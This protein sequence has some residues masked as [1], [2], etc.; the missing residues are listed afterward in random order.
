MRVILTQD[1]PN[2]GRKGEVKTVADGYAR[3]LLLP[4][5]LAVVASPEAIL[6]LEAQKFRQ[7]KEAEV[8]LAETQKLAAQ[9]EGKAIEIAAKAN[10]DGKLYAAVTSAKVVTALKA[11]GFIVS[12]QRMPNLSIKELGEHELAIPLP[13]GLDA[14]I[15]LVIIPQE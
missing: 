5:K 11:H 15:T 8:E 1:V 3:N 7:A 2:L 14:R 10:A 4:K 13:H 9:L 12:R 6:A